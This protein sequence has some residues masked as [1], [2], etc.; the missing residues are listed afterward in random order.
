MSIE[1]YREHNELKLFMHH[2]YEYKKGVRNLFLCTTS[3]ICGN[4]LINRLQN[5]GIPFTQQKVSSR[6]VNIYFGKEA[7]INVV[8]SF[9]DK[10]LNEL[11]AEE[12]FMLGTMLGYDITMQCD[13]YWKRKK[14]VQTN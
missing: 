4:L 2:I 14:I 11:T 8:K 5:Q 9:I 3:F 12:D 13:R 10:P 6:K 7:C 1:E